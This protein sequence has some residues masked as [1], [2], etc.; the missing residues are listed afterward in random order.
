MHD[1]TGTLLLCGPPCRPP[2]CVSLPPELPRRWSPSFGSATRPHADVRR[3]E[4]SG[5]SG[6]GGGASPANPSNGRRA[7]SSCRLVPERVQSRLEIRLFPCHMSSITCAARP[8]SV[9]VNQSA[10]IRPATLARSVAAKSGEDWSGICAFCSTRGQASR[11]AG[12]M[13]GR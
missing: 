1:L 7:G 10:Q 13:S 4:S 9:F 8:P 2:T 12:R 6:A 5:C 11:L 3:G